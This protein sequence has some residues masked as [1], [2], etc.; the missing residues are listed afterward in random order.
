MFSVFVKVDKCGKNPSFQQGHFSKTE[1]KL[2]TEH[3]VR[4]FVCEDLVL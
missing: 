1:Q 3:D 4:F 2:K